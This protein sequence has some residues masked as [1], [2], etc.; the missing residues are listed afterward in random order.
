MI[1]SSNSM[2]ENT[3]LRESGGIIRFGDSDDDL[4]MK[5]WDIVK[6]AVDYPVYIVP[7]YYKDMSTG[8]FVLADG[9]SGTGRDKDFHL[10]VVDKFR[11]GENQAISTVS[12]KYG[13]LET[14]TVY[15]ELQKQ[16]M[17]V[18]D[19]GEVI[20]H[21]IRSL[22]ISGNGGQQFLT[23]SIKDMIGMNG[24]P[25]EISM[26]IQLSTSVDGSKAHT[27]QSIVHNKTA[28][29][30]HFVHGEANYKLA[31][32]HTNTVQ[33]RSVNFITTIKTMIMNWNDVIIPTMAIMFDNK[34]N[35]NVGLD[36][37]NKICKETG[38]GERH[39]TKIRELYR[40][41]GVRTNASDDSL[42]RVN[43]V[44]GEYIDDELE[45]RK[46]LQDRFKEGVA[47]S[48][49]REVKKIKQ[50]K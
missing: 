41:T 33:T 42:Y 27:L 14:K 4:N 46:E 26:L 19:D 13:T 2:D 10:V 38:I 18:D 3:I 45:D 17:T 8:E 5:S 28:D 9:E 48:I 39:N 22:Y 34:F 44:F 21:N 36:L 43:H 32:R 15:E 1:I 50:S 24:I 40:S 16:L 23:L 37:I 29:T 30:T 49:A 47:K 12:G 35:Q 11:T 31:V 6:D 7:A 20:G 25:D